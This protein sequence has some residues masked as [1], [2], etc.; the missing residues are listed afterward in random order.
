MYDVKCRSQYSAGK[1]GKYL[2]TVPWVKPGSKQFCG[3]VSVSTENFWVSSEQKILFAFTNDTF[4]VST[5][6][7]TV[8]VSDSKD[9]LL[10]VGKNLECLY[11]EKVS[12]YFIGVINQMEGFSSPAITRFQSNIHSV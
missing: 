4:D 3:S 12:L 6:L 8:L 9:T 11:G 7:D 2:D 5:S 1:V 10:G